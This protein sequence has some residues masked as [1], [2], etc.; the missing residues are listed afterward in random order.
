[1]ELPGQRDRVWSIRIVAASCAPAVPGPCALVGTGS[2]RMMTDDKDDSSELEELLERIRAGSEEAAWDFIEIYGPH[3]RRIVR[4][5]LDTQLR[6]QFDSLDFVQMVWASFFCEPQEIKEFDGPEKLIGYLATVARNKVVQEYRRRVRTQKY[7]VTRERS[8][9][10]MDPDE[11]SFSRNQATPSQVA[12][13]RERWARILKGQPER[14]RRIVQMRI[15]GATFEE[16][17]RDL[18]IHER[19]ARKIMD[20]LL[21]SESPSLE[22]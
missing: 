21:R 10:E 2:G 18:G 1:M 4:R 7:N 8:L 9:E 6:S 11:A 20:Q 22:E 19:T 14:H 5:K 17:G 12:M 3:L 13:A 15:H 16:I